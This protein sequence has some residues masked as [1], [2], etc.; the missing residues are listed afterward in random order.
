MAYLSFEGVELVG[1]GDEG[2]VVAGWRP[3]EEGVQGLSVALAA[4]LG[5]QGGEQGL[6]RVRLGDGD[7]YEGARRVR[8]VERRAVAARSRALALR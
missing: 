7:A 8:V 5:G 6:G 3:E 1:E 4:E 2:R